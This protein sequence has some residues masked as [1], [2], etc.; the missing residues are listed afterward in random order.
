VSG[1]MFSV[2]L[3][4]CFSMMFGMQ[5]MPMGRM[6]VLGR[7]VDIIRIVVFGGF[8]VMFGR[9]RM[10]FGGFFVVI[11]NLLRMGHR[12]FSLLPTDDVSATEHYRRLVTD[13]P[14]RE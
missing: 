10:M 4:G 13:S 1:V 5:V 14:A 7:G 8:A 6:S 11:G 3:A 12:A 9:L 2:E